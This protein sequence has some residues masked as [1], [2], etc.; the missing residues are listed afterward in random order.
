[1][2]IRNMARQHREFQS[3]LDDAEKLRLYTQ[4]VISKHQ[5]LDA[6]LA[7]AE[8]RSKHWEREAKAG[9]KK[10]RRA[11]KEREE[12]RHEAK[13]AQLVVIA[14]GEAKARVEDDLVRALDALATTKEDRHRQRLR[15]PAWWLSERH[16][17]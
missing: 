12:A 2:T 10:I 14:A 15:L 17:F 4:S 7:K 16:F 1:M 6:S 3:R 9:A 8:S 11:E 13:V 5:G